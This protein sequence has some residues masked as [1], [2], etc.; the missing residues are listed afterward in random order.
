[1]RARH[2]DELSRE[3]AFRL[4]GAPDC[5]NPDKIPAANQTDRMERAVGRLS[6]TTTQ[7]ASVP[8]NARKVD[9]IDKGPNFAIEIGID[10]DIAL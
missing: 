6:S 10:L 1:M 5:A 9:A 4:Q 8:A 7:R 2:T 3:A